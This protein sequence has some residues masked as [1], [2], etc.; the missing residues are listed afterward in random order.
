LKEETL[1]TSTLDATYTNLKDTVRANL[2]FGGILSPTAK[3]RVFD[4]PV[5][6]LAVDLNLTFASP[7]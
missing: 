5:P 3:L 2:R 4:L 1:L 7:E 6:R